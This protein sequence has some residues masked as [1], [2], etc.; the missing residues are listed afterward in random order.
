MPLALSLKHRIEA[1]V[2]LNLRPIF[3]LAAEL[4]LWDQ[5]PRPQGGS[6]LEEGS[7]V[8]QAGCPAVHPSWLDRSGALRRGP[9]VHWVEAAVP[10]G[11][12]SGESVPRDA[13][14]TLPRAPSEAVAGERCHA[15]GAGPA[16]E[17]LGLEA[18]APHRAA[19][20]GDSLASAGG[21]A[22]L[23]VGLKPQGSARAAGT[24]S[25]RCSARWLRTTGPGA[26]GGPR[27]N[28]SAS[29]GSGCRREP[30]AAPCQEGP[31]W[32]S[33]RCTLG[34]HLRPDPR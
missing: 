2:V 19:R 1:S 5:P 33:A 8:I 13:I 15:G 4:P 34:A 23:V 14:G 26:R 31:G 20:D 9:G 6:P 28:A 7:P 32:E 11:P 25:G 12:R 17:V 3:R 24:L 10:K 27:R 18:G 16:G 30:C 29:W 22:R 21:S